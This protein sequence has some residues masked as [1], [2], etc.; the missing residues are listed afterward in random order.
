MAGQV[1]V[2][3]ARTKYSLLASAPLSSWGPELR[4]NLDVLHFFEDWGKK[5]LFDCTALEW[6][7]ELFGYRL[8][9]CEGPSRRPRYYDRTSSISSPGICN[10]IQLRSAVTTGSCSSSPVTRQARSPKDKP[11]L[12]S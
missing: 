4:P 8:I 1:E 9:A 2:L 5:E 12:R 10:P 7:V 11:R 3:T 6:G